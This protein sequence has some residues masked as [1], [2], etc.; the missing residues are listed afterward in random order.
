MASRRMWSRRGM[1]KVLIDNRRAGGVAMM[2]ISRMPLIA[3]LSVLGIGV[4]VSARTS[5][6]ARSSRRRSF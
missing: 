1:T 3:I 4:A 5:T 2:D 6:S